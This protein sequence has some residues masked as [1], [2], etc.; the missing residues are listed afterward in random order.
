MVMDR[1]VRML[2]LKATVVIINILCSAN[3]ELSHAK[4]DENSGA[5]ISHFIT[6]CLKPDFIHNQTGRILSCIYYTAT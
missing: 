5:A 3:I 6:N 4:Q 2:N 1:K